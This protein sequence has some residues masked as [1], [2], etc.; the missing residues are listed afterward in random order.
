MSDP[1]T[2]SMSLPSARSDH[3]LEREIA[4]LD[5][6]EGVRKAA[7]AL[8][9][10]GEGLARRIFRV[11]SESEI[12]TVIQT[13]ERLR[14]VSAEEVLTVLEEFTGAI[15]AQVTGVAGHE[16]MIQQAAEAALGREVLTAILGRDSGGASAKLE[17]AAT[18][19]PV[20]FSAVLRREHP[21]VVA[22]VL[23]M[24]SPRV[25]ATVLHQLDPELRAVIVERVATIRSVPADV[26]A[27]V[28]ELV[29]QE[30]RLPDE[31]GPVQ[32][33]GRETAVGILKAVGR[34]SEHELFEALT[35]RDADLAEDLRSRMFV[36]EDL[37]GLQ[38]RDIQFLLREVD[39]LTLAT[40]LKTASGRLKDH[41]LKNMS[42]RAAMSVL[43]DMEIIS[44]G[45]R[46]KIAAAQAE[47]VSSV[48]QLAAQEKIELRPDESL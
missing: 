2:H 44:D 10:L 41:V 3:A 47:L 19:D 11:L 29:E 37:L 14:G 9:V 30:M 46:V 26:L 13:A 35:A 45:S 31:V 40:A 12:E 1:T 7:I 5:G 36:F 17:L 38:D 33:D 16:H 28:A 15:D 34:T 22:V 23:A 43:E 25:S 4:G 8:L 42:S 32:F 39:R 24:L 18:R 48:L 20:S 6:A 27:Q 21:Q